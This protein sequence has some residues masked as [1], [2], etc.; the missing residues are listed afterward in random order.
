MAE[1]ST[2][3]IILVASFCAPDTCRL[4]IS[5]IAYWLNNT[6]IQYV[7]ARLILTAAILMLLLSITFIARPVLSAIYSLFA[8]AK[9][10]MNSLTGVIIN[11]TFVTNSTAS[12][13]EIV[14]PTLISTLCT[15][16]AGVP[17]L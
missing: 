7:F 5:L 3:H 2:V 15:V 10:G 13:C 6:I 14:D 16:L 4:I 12:L 8:M 11:S 1:S 9:S 17:V